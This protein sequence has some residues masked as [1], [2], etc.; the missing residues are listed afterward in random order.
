MKGDDTSDACT[1]HVPVETVAAVP[2]RK[3]QTDRQTAGQF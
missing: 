2:E 3:A 1:A